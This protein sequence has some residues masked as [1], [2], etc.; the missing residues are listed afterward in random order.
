MSNKEVIP[1][2]F[3]QSERF[4]YFDPLNFD[5]S[6]NDKVVVE[7]A[8]GLELGIV[9]SGKKSVSDSE[10][11]ME[12]KPVVRIA[13]DKDIKSY[14]K[15]IKDSQK[16]LPVIKEV[17][18]DVNI[19]FKLIGCSYTLD[20]S[21]L[22][23][24]FSFSQRIDFRE[25]VRELAKE[26]K[27]RIEMRQVGERD[28]ARYIG[29]IGPCGLNICCSTFL[30]DFSVINMKLAKK[31]N[32]SLN[33]QKISGL[34]Q[35]LLCCIKYEVEVYDELRKNLPKANALLKTPVGKHKMVSSN[36]LKQTV[37]V[38]DE[39]GVMH[40]FSVKEV[41]VVNFGKNN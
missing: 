40:E 21:K 26:F 38:R 33:P 15:N 18:E 30:G 6:K 34:C 2:K 37:K 29:G 4:Y 35:K 25:L 3:N 20:R 12:L 27:T 39:Q 28:A 41:K 32:L 17:M 11:E 10:I 13:T 1:I 22:V 7:T 23:V 14:E 16:N 31:Q 24:Y 19:H 36:I 5:L 8:R 9:Q